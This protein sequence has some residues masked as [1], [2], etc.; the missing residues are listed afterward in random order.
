M[1]VEKLVKR[2]LGDR[3]NQEEQVSLMTL[4]R[5]GEQTGKVGFSSGL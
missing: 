3:A 1:N 4:I 5:I 2:I